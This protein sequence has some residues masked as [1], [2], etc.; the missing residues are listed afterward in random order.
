M[1]RGMQFAARFGWQMDGP[2]ARVCASL[3]DAYGEL[4]VE[5][6]AEEWRKALTKGQHFSVMLGEL[7]RTGWL[8][9]YAELVALDGL[10][11]DPAWHPE[12]DL[13]TH[14][15]LAAE[16]A[17]GLAD[18]A[19]LEGDDRYVV[20]AAAML[21]DIGKATTTRRQVGQDGSEHVVSPGHAQ[22]GEDPTESFLVSI[23][24]PEH[25]RRRV[26]PLVAEHMAAT[27]SGGPTE[28]AVR[29]LARRLAPATIEGRV[30]VVR[31]DR[32][33]RGRLVDRAGEVERWLEVARDIGT[34]RAPGASVAHRG[35]PDSCRLGAGLGPFSSMV[36]V[37]SH[38]VSIA[39]VVLLVEAGFFFVGAFV[40]S[41][42]HAEHGI[43]A[44]VADEAGVPSRPPSGS[45]PGVGVVGD[46]VAA[47]LAAGKPQGVGR[48]VHLLPFTVSTKQAQPPACP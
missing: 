26:V 38:A 6:V 9:H 44:P 33:G 25:L 19:G 32:S 48:H 23:G 37:L 13:P 2:T 29:R 22:A 30:L 42:K 45:G 11:Q 39:G 35:P 7:R 16:V 41:A 12:G 1:L 20:V 36:S 21:H 10:E 28:R 18:E 46:G 43:C 24:C 31:A 4:P 17:A 27:M 8:V 5:R 34:D 3:S 14:S 40:V 47:A 15:G